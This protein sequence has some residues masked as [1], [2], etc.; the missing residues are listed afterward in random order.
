MPRR[1][2]ER[3]RPRSIQSY[4]SPVFERTLTPG[5]Q[6]RE[7]VYHLSLYTHDRLTTALKNVPE[8]ILALDN[9][10]APSRDLRPWPVLPDHP[11]LH[12]SR[13]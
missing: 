8:T 6:L 2:L 12:P 7:R 5:G 1:H 9:P 13:E 4:C 10:D 3:V 11:R